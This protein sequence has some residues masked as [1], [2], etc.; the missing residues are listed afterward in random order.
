[1]GG[2]LSI[3]SYFSIRTHRHLF[4]YPQKSF[5]FS[6]KSKEQLVLEY[7]GL[8][9]VSVKYFY[10]QLLSEIKNAVLNDDEESFE[11]LN[12]LLNYVIASKSSEVMQKYEQIALEA[13]GKINLI[14]F[15]C[16]TAAG[17]I[18]DYLLTDQNVNF[19]L[20]FRIDKCDLSPEEEDEESH[21]AFY[22]AIRSN[23]TS[24]LEI[25]I[26]KWPNSYFKDTQKLDDILS[27]AFHE[28]SI[29]NV[30]LTK[31]MEMHVKKKLVDLRFFHNNSP[32][33][34]QPNNAKDLLM[35]RIEFVLE[36][37]AFVVTN[38]C[39]DKNELDEQFLL[40]AK[41]IAQNIHTIKSQLN[42]TYDKVPW[43]EMEFCLI[44]FLRFCLK[45]FR[46]EPLYYF[47]LNKQRLLSHLENFSK[48]LECVKEELNTV[49][50]SKVPNKKI[51]R[52]QVIEKEENKLFEN[53]YNDFAQ[54]RDLYTLEKIKK[55]TNIALSADP[56]KKEGHILITRA[57]QVTGEHF[58]NTP[59][60]PK[61]SDSTA[62]FLL[63]V[64]P[65]NVSDII[66]SLRN[67]L[68][69]LEAF[70]LRSEI[71]ENANTFF[72]NIQ[73]DITKISS[74]ISD[75]LYKKKIAVIMTLLSRMISHESIDSRKIFVEQNHT[76]VASF[77][78]VLEEAK[79]L[80][81]G[82]IGQLEKLVSNLEVELDKEIIYSKKMF[83]RLHDVLEA[84]PT[85]IP[86]QSP[87]VAAELLDSLI[88]SDK[89]E[90]MKF[91]K[92]AVLNVDSTSLLTENDHFVTDGK[93]DIDKVN[94]VMVKCFLKNNLTENKV[95]LNRIKE[96]D[97]TIMWKFF[98]QCDDLLQKLP[99]EME[100][101]EYCNPEKIQMLKKLVLDVEAL[102]ER[103]SRSEKE[104]FRRILS[105]IADKKL[106][107]KKVHEELS[108]TLKNSFGMIHTEDKYYSSTQIM[109]DICNFRKTIESLMYQID[110]KSFSDDLYLIAKSISSRMLLEYGVRGEAL[111]K[112]LLDIFDFVVFRMGNIKWIE[113][114][115][116]MIHI[117]KKVKPY[118]FAKNVYTLKPNFAQQLTRKI[119]LLRSVLKNHNLEG[120]S[121]QKLQACDKNMELQILVEMLVLDILSVIEGLKDQLTHINF[122]LDSYYPT[123][124]G[125]NLRN[126]V[127][128]GNAL[129]DMILGE[130]FTNILLNAQK[131]IEVKDILQEKLG[132]KVE[133]D[134]VKS[135]N[136]HENDLSIMK[137]Q[138]QFFVSLAEGSDIKRVK[139]FI[140]E[141]VDVY[142]RDLNSSTAL[143]FAA[144]APNPE[145]L[146]FLLKF[147]LNVYAKDDNHQT[148]L[149]VAAN[150]GMEEI[151]EYLIEEMKMPVDEKDINGKTPLHIASKKGH[152]SVVRLL[153][154][155][156]ANAL[157]NDVFGYAPLHYAVLENHFNV[158][159]ALLENETCVDANQTFYGF[160]AL[161]LAAAMGHLNIVD[162]L[163]ENGVD[164]NFKSDMDYVP[165]HSAASGGHSE[166]VQSLL[167]KGADVNAQNV[168]GL[169]PLHLAV[170]S[171]DVATIGILLQH[172]AEVN[173]TYLN[174]FTPF[175][176]AAEDGSF[177]VSKLLMEGGAAVARSSGN[178]ATPLDV[179]AYF[180]HCEL[181]EELLNGADTNSKILAMQ[182][183][184]SRGH[185]AVVELILNRGVDV[186]ARSVHLDSTA[187]H[188]AAEEGHADTVKFLVNR[189]ADINAQDGNG[190]TALHLS[191]RKERKE[192]V[193]LLIE[194]KADILIK[195]NTGTFP[196]EI[197]VRK[198]M[199]D[200]LIQEEVTF[201][202]SYATDINPFHYGAY[203]GDINFV[204]YCIQKGCN[205]DIRTE[206]GLTALHLATLGGREEVINF[207]LANGSD[208]NA[209]DQKGCTAL[210]LA[211]SE[212][213]KKILE[214]L[215]KKGANLNTVQ[216]RSLF[217]SA[218]QHG[219]ENIVDFFLSR[220]SNVG[221][222]N[223]QNGE[224]PLHMAVIFGHI[225]VV[226]K[227]L[228]KSKKD[229]L[230]VMDE[231]F[232]T[233]LL[234]A[235]EKDDCEISQLLLSK[236][237]DPN[238]SSKDGKLPLLIATARGNS[239]MVEILL[240][241]GVDYL[242]KDAK[243]KTSIELA[244][245]SRQTNIVEVLLQNP[246]ILNIKGKKN[247][248]LLHIAA[249]SGSL[250]II[251]LLIENKVDI[252]SMDSSGAKPI[253]MTAKEGYL[254][255]L[256]YFLNLEIAVDER[257][258]NDWTSMHYAAAG[259]HSEICKFLFE[260]GADVNAVNTDGATPLHTAGEMGNLNALLTLLELGA[261]YDAC[262][263]N[264]KT[265]LEVTEWWNTRI[266]ISLMF[267][268][269]LFS[270]V[271]SNSR[272][273]LVGLL[274][275][276]LDILK[277]NF[278]NVKNA[279]NTASIHYAAWKGYERIVNILLRYRANPNSRTKNGWTS[280][281]YAAKFS[282]YGIT[283][284]LLCNGAVFEATSDSG[285]T[286]LHY[287][288]NTDVITILKFLKKMF[289]KIESKDRSS[290]EDLKAI[291]DMDIA[292]AV[293]RAKNLQYRTLTSVAIIN[294]HPDTDELKEI[295]QTDVFIPL[296]MAEM[297][298]RHGNFEES[299]NLYQEVLQKRIN[300]FYQDDPAV[301]D[302]QKQVALL[303]VYYGD[304]NGGLSLAQKVHETL[305][306]ILGDRNRETLTVKCLIALTLECTGQ[307]QKALKNYEEISETQREVLGLNH[308]ETLATLTSMA[309][310]L[311]KQNK[312]EMAL[313]VNEEILKTLTDYYEINPWALRI[314]TN[315]ATILRKQEKFSEA[316]KM[317]RNISVAKEKIFGF[318][319][320]ETLETST[321]IAVTLLHMGQEEESL[322][323]FRKNVELQVNLLGPGHPD[324]LRSRRG[325]ANILFSQ[326]K[327]R[328][329]LDIYIEDLEA[330]ILRLGAN[331]PSIE[332][333][334]KRIDFIN[335]HITKPVF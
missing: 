238:I 125:R 321:E 206:S 25:L 201:E 248:S 50:I 147:N 280:L 256:E 90:I 55:Y 198:G 183:A 153:L 129:V 69:H 10:I 96:Q 95:I 185:L 214:L 197:F 334:R 132:K 37:I 244:I 213:N 202:F 234:I 179:A 111:E 171:G 232:R 89:K 285:K 113:E 199:T 41:F 300:I 305:Q 240:N 177:A 191:S 188:F 169:T 8:N 216:E 127:A 104:Q 165:L 310:L 262:D 211:V 260:N 335:S 154:K 110:L 81:L 176:L 143:H 286:P 329:A 287:S 99:D 62:A 205:V 46:F 268:S 80:N 178:G 210:K 87:D 2:V 275:A 209:E 75:I 175:Y 276:G 281:H 142:G 124:Y 227:M 224:Y 170:D 119:S 51:I 283:K 273:K 252:N 100:M 9:A 267:A 86:R 297:F 326:R 98:P 13:V 200:F 78:K 3:V 68:S 225:S 58:N 40:A 84:K 33:K 247:R 259:N 64:L 92:H 39:D 226:K 159:T 109:R 112:T 7:N 31:D 292:K 189:G 47:V 333:T 166:V 59:T 222:A 301:L 235:A 106:N 255:I 20:P 35:L 32:Q 29:R 103:K 28:L 203:Y 38:Y 311:Y 204:S 6:S 253:H 289:L 245:E 271:Q 71:E 122:Y 317:I 330:R 180:G 79:H 223:F 49:D 187:L 231:N 133:N 265:P 264:A 218:V 93:I 139:D 246:N 174:G 70:C 207:L 117:H 212:N 148:A 208:I 290:M 164:V 141:G 116:H 172:G 144:R 324:T 5:T 97:V 14:T 76:S 72:V 318:H 160:T 101:A 123:A 217:L 306:S 107:L 258:E 186:K 138:K 53:L 261:F 274:M 66:T 308:R 146:K 278:V 242:V 257:G 228:E 269:N 65:K 254:D 88:S 190:D 319:H 155:H 322:K 134:P 1:M 137:K 57:L 162:S 239:K 135:K 328:E 194:M 249:C 173:A 303:M 77:T 277:F 36:K 48:R 126:H 327:F 26:D 282:H 19:V 315:I 150:S 215:I 270:A 312:F 115:K 313:K 30:P 263:K 42:F 332:K 163:L 121:V 82:E 193:K 131:I 151:V 195:D 295:F 161:H 184:A 140:S 309:E 24:L 105:M 294:D 27:K 284:D 221:A 149:H 136:S 323:I 63:S 314:Q 56:R 272:F 279:K 296:K 229:E 22:Y 237:A 266:K 157:F 304:Y 182:R 288:T 167:K 4:R 196:L 15:A 156:K 316:L 73:A 145:I 158:V 74:A 293:V 52:K 67:S 45:A 325:I 114:F 307:E 291:E 61:L 299:F 181:V 320:Q 118:T 83:L 120:L 251:E 250:E 302:I 168:Q 230:N 12:S 152:E 11:T 233:P 130:N 298:Y 108:E 18:L 241:S 23:V 192:V 236:G 85:K 102:I 91:L 243:E 54:I 17:K 43:E 128:H 34:N 44:I 219:H 220:N 16:K 21:N 60:A 94:K 331:H